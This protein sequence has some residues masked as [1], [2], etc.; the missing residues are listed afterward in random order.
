[1]SL[2]TT[3]AQHGAELP[4]T[5]RVDDSA[6]SSILL[7]LAIVAVFFGGFGGWA[8]LAPLNGA[9]VANAVVTVEG[10]RKTVQHLDGGI[11]KELLVKEGDRVA[12]G[13]LLIRLDDTQARAEFNVLDQ[14]FTMLEAKDARLNAELNGLSNIKFPR[15]LAARQDNNALMALA[16]QREEFDKRRDALAGQRDVL[17]KRIA[18]VEAKIAGEEL[19]LAAYRA[20][21]QSVT[22]EEA[23]L[24]DLLAKGLIT[25]ARTLQLQRTNAGLEGQIGS[26]E[27]AIA[28]DRKTVEGYREQIDQLQKDRAAEISKDLSDTRSQLLDVGSRRQNAAAVLERTEIR[29]PYSGEIVNL[30]VFGTGAV[31]GRG[32]KIMDIVPDGTSL[33]VEGHVRVQDISELHPGMAA[34]VHF[35]SYD[36]RVVPAIHG[37][38][39]KIS[40]DRL[41]DERTGIPYYL[42]TISTDAKELAAV[43]EIKLYPGMPATVVVPTAKRTALDYLF[44]P[45]VASFDHSFRER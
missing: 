45:L 18:E 26:T 2:L 14:Q 22:D 9:V 29:A 32:E 40:A 13:D 8:A 10:N 27:G 39:T 7:G 38:L 21:L 4:A 5:P 43:P 41:T 15:D 12:A 36:Q 16:G 19:Q 1:M 35:T 31:I 37:S 33:V 30:G 17:A 28:T 44:G 20:Q 34:E 11:V 25:R 24:A 42:A 23:S 3:P 6:R